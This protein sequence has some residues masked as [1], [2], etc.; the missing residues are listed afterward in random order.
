MAERVDPDDA[1]TG[2]EVLAW[3]QHLEMLQAQL[4]RELGVTETTIS[5]WERN[6]RNVFSPRM[7]RLALYGLACLHGKA[8]RPSRSAR[9]TRGT[10]AVVL[11]RG[12]PVAIGERRPAAAAGG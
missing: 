8:P 7:V 6:Q 4:A 9:A 3:R 2:D 12:T 10:T 1:L 11:V 5:R